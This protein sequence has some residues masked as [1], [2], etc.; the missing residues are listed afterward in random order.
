[1]LGRQQQ[2][3]VPQPGITAG[4]DLPG[5]SSGLHQGFQSGRFLGKGRS[6]QKGGQT[7][8][9]GGIHLARGL[10]GGLQLIGGGLGDKQARQ[11]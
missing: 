1:M 2:R 6:S 11:R 8:G 5:I 10:Q 4:Q 3:I 9:H 7:I